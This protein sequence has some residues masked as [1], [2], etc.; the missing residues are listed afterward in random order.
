M[1][2]ELRFEPEGAYPVSPLYGLLFKKAQ[3]F[4]IKGPRLFK[5][6]EVPAAFERD[7][8]CVG[9]RGGP[10]KRL[11]RLPNLLLPNTKLSQQKQAPARE[12]AHST[13]V[14]DLDGQ[15]QMALRVA[16]MHFTLAERDLG[17]QPV[18]LWFQLCLPSRNAE[19]QSPLASLSCPLEL[20]SDPVCLS[21]AVI[22]LCSKRC[23]SE[24]FGELQAFLQQS[25]SFTD[26]PLKDGSTEA[27][28][29]RDVP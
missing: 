28:A 18:K 16:E 9:H 10:V 1:I 5:I 27:L 12:E 21:Q 25:D 2:L 19:L 7:Q 23:V 11:S 13:I 15:L 17:K 20:L 14:T 26:S 3:Q 8:S 29:N 22:G 4:S 24:L 6:W